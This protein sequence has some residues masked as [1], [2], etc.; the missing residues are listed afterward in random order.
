MS[1]INR[2]KL[3]RSLIISIISPSGGQNKSSLPIMDNL[4]TLPLNLYPN[5][6]PDG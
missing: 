4:S 6:G 3:N 5:D 2:D 1:W